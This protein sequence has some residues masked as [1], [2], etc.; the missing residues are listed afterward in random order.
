MTLNIFDTTTTVKIS[1]DQ[2]AIETNVLA[3][4]GQSGI[5]SVS[6]TDTRGDLP[7]MTVNYVIGGT[8]S[9]GV[10]YELLSGKVSFVNGARSTN[11]FVNTIERDLI[12]PDLTVTL[13]IITNGNAYDI[14]AAASNDTVT[15]DTSVDVLDVAINL[16]GPVG[17]DYYAPSNSL[18]VS[19]SGDGNFDIIFTNIAIVD[20]QTVTNVVVTN[21]SGITEL[22]DEVYLVAPRIPAGSLTNAAGFTNGDLFF[23]SGTGI[24]WLS[25]GGTRSNLNW[26]ILTNSV[27]TNALPLRG[28]ICLD[29][30]GTFSNQLIA[31]TSPGSPTG[32]LKGVWRIDANAHPTF[33]TNISAAHLEGVVALT[34]DAEKWGPWAGK[35]ITGDE[36]AAKIYT[37]AFNGSIT[38]N[39]TSNLIAGGIAPESFNVVPTNCSLYISDVDN[40]EVV[41]IQEAY[42]RN[43]VGDLLISEAG[44]DSAPGIFIIHWDSGTS[45]FLTTQI[46]LPGSILHIEGTTF[47]PIQLPRQL[48]P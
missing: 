16:N 26:C 46:R 15:I 31:V 13:T 5:F 37:I 8:A 4:V 34:N 10:D 36:A 11:I 35:I 21:W 30:T 25:A 43:N 41:E 27:V 12:E 7:P 2:N 47:A 1:A 44:E 40:N 33:I 38:T 19:E 29:Q 23:G 22:P 39:S 28:G 17:I 45:N 18:I 6:R 32:D 24:G 48:N 9:N 20:G 14:D 42:F 3:G